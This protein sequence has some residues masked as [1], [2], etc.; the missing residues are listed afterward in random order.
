MKSALIQ[1]F[2][3]MYFPAFGLNTERY[4]VSLR[5]QSKCG[6]IRT[7]KKPPKTSI[8]LMN[9]ITRS[10]TILG[11]NKIVPLYFPKVIF[12]IKLIYSYV[13]KYGKSYFENHFWKGKP[14][15]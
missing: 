5:I 8:F 7:K 1:S 3:G 2:S 14:K 11:L 9:N 12:K 6:K 13:Q 10:L 15:Y 4:G